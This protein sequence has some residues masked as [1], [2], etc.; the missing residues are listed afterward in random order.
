[1]TQLIKLKSA[2][3]ANRRRNDNYDATN[4]V[5]NQTI[6]FLTNNF[7][8]YSLY[9]HWSHVTRKMWIL[10]C[11]FAITVIISRILGLELHTS[12]YRRTDTD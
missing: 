7:P 5:T 12:H 11:R 3:S 6:L 1:M 8:L 4:Q 9:N 2:S 10:E